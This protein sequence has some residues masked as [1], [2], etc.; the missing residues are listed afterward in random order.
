MAVPEYDERGT[1]SVGQ[2]CH[3]NIAQTNTIISGAVQSTR[4]A[5]TKRK[6][7]PEIR[8]NQREQPHRQRM[9]DDR[10]KRSILSVGGTAQSVT[11]LNLGPPCTE[12]S[13]PSIQPIVDANRLAKDTTTPAIMIACD[14]RN[15]HTA[16]TQIAQRSQRRHGKGRD[17]PSPLEPEIEDIAVQDQ[18]TGTPAQVAK[19]RDQRPLAFW[20]RGTDM[21]V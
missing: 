13:G 3:R 21:A 15:G 6:P 14:P 4:G 12:V 8:V 5:G 10:P 2:S 20:R 17:A 11:V 1:V 16:I 7:C 19:K 9:A 18:R